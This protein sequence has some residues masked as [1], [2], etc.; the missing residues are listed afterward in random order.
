MALCI[1]IN[2]CVD[3]PANAHLIAAAPAL[4]EALKM[5]LRLIEGENLDEKFDGEAEVLREALAQADR[6]E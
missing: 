6:R 5:M 1:I 3:G 2:D 4:Y